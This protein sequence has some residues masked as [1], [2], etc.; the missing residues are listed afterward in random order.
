M[1]DELN[2]NELESI[3]GGIPYESAKEMAEKLRDAKNRIIE[4]DI[5]KDGKLVGDEIKNAGLEDYTKINE[6]SKSI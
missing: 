4:S 6:N 3:I 5:N 2:E 1:N